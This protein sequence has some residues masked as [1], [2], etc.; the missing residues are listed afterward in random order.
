MWIFVHFFQ[1]SKLYEIKI[2]NEHI[3]I[4]KLGMCVR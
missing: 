2:L 3:G 4:Y 1:L